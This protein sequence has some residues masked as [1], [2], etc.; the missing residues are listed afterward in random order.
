MQ[1][2]R[3]PLRQ[4]QGRLLQKTQGWGTLQWEWCTQRSLKLGHPPRDTW[5]NMPENRQLTPIETEFVD[6]LENEYKILQ[7]KIDKIGAFRFTIKGWS[8][9]VIL[10]AAF[11]SASAVKIPAWLWLVSLF[12]FLVLFFLFELE[13]TTLRHKFGQRCILIESA[14]TRVLRTAATS[15]GDTIVRA[16]FVKLHSV[17]G[18]TNHLRKK[19]AGSDFEEWS[20]WRAFREADGFFYAA[21]GLLTLLFA[22]W[23]ATAAKQEMDNTDRS[24]SNVI[25]Y[26]PKSESPRATGERQD[27]VSG[28]NDRYEPQEKKSK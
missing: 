6:K 23:H 9:T 26:A 10:A 5:F 16:Q 7:D 19:S 14:I 25:I 22:A 2:R 20:R 18:I 28:S 21:L 13:Q 3:P 4:A 17:P 27:A 11:A 15:S 24:R 1:H 12:G 8:I